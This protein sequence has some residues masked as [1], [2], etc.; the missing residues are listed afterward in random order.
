M[1]GQS[2]P[3]IRIYFSTRDD[4]RFTHC[5]GCD[6]CWAAYSR[7]LMDA[8][9]SYPSPASLPANLKRHARSQLVADGIIEERGHGCFVVHGL[10][11][12]RERRSTQ[13]REAVGQRWNREYGTPGIP[14]KYDRNTTELPG[15]I[16]A[17]PSLAEPNQTEPSHA[18]ESG[19]D[20]WYWV[21]TRYPDKFAKPQLWDWLTRLENDFGVVPLWE[22]MRLAFSQDHTLASLLSRTE[23]ALLRNADREAQRVKAEKPKPNGLD[24]AAYEENRRRLAAGEV[25]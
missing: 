14:P 17:E 7:L 8:E 9:G 23:A 11:K 1:S 15:V 2:D 16:L 21:T 18:P 5:Y 3:Y 20:V 24:K 4:S 13:A 22:A 25:V 6:T 12:E 19:P 10:E